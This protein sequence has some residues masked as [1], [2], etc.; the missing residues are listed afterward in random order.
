MTLAPK[1]RAWRTLCRLV[2][3][4]SQAQV[5][6]SLGV[7]QQ[8]VSAY[9]RRASRPTGIRRERMHKVLGIVESDWDTAEERRF[10]EGS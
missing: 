3:E 5:A 10:A 4:S 2:D 7:C 1:T 8:T 6:E 9:Y